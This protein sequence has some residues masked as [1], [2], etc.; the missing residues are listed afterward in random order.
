MRVKRSREQHS[1]GGQRP[2]CVTGITEFPRHH[3]TASQSH[4]SSDCHRADHTKITAPPHRLQNVGDTTMKSAAIKFGLSVFLLLGWA[5]IAAALPASPDPAVNMVSVRT[6]RGYLMIA[7]VSI[8]DRG[9]FDFL[10]DTGSNTTLLDP[11]LAAELGLQP[12]DTLQLASL[13]QSTGVPRYFL[14][15]LTVGTA[16]LSNLEALA[17]PLTQLRALDSNIR[18]ILGMNFLLHFSFRLD[19]ERPALELYSS[20]ETAR[21]PAGLRVPVQINQA[22]LLV[23]V[24]SGAALHGG[25]R[26]ALDSGISQF[27]IF[28]DRMA[29]LDET[30]CSESTCLMQVSTNLAQQNAATRRLRDMSI[31][32]SDARLPEQ[33]VVVLRNDLQPATDPQD[34]L[35][36]AAPFH[37][38]FFDRSTATLIISP[39][40]EATAVAALQT[41]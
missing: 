32:C 36:P 31:A 18:G 19:F 27:L 29:H 35:L 4:L 38:I 24:A 33:E 39:S 1:C 5:T 6:V 13:A 23:P 15:K 28:G 14:D 12:R 8:N 9:P 11:S 34:G 22:R 3:S 37:S 40:P 25:W 17:L 41:H 21:V 7:Q 30:P 16:S 26:L 2:L 20:P 10:V